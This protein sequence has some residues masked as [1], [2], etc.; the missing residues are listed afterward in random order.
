MAKITGKNNNGER[1]DGTKEADEIRLLDGDDTCVADLGDDTVYGGGGN[2]T[3]YAR[4]TGTNTIVDDGNDFFS[5]EGGNDFIYGGT[6][7]D[8]LDGGDGNDWLD[9]ENGND[10][11]T[12]GIGNDTLDGGSWLLERVCRSWRGFIFGSRPTAGR[13]SLGLPRAVKSVSY[14]N[15]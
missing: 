13:C 5:G 12:G 9:G 10:S 11:L 15:G 6:G 8:T 1:L 14:G 3:I 2:D 7:N 4:Y